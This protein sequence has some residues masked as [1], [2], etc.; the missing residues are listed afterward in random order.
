MVNTVR[1]PDENS[2][3]CIYKLRKIVS[4]IYQSVTLIDVFLNIFPARKASDKLIK[5]SG[6]LFFLSSLYHLSKLT[7]Y[8]YG[9]NCT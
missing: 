8:W 6:L 3:H 7:Y 4:R 9:E 5:S 2:G 1:S